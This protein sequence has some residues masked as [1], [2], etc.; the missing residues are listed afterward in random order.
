MEL[1]F[2]FCSLMLK[3]YALIF[4]AHS[5]GFSV[6]IKLCPALYQLSYFGFR[7]KAESNCRHHGICFIISILAEWYQISLLFYMG[8]YLAKVSWIVV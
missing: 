6:Q 7:Q 8:L 1:N 5:S 2:D 4:T 3:L